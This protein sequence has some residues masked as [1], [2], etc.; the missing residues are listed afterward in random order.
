MSKKG[1][2]LILED[3]P[4]DQE[5]ITEILRRLQ[6]KNK[7]L[8]FS[9]GVAFLQY[10]QTTTDNPFIII[11]DSNIPRMNGW[12]VRQKIKEAP[13]LFEKGIPFIYFSTDGSTIA[14][15][16]AYRF[17]VQGFFIKPNTLQEME[18]VFGQIIGYWTACLYPNSG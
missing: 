14:V 7:L 10:L 17:A 5:M 2:I 15:K 6:V 18:A 3:D 11:S 13:Y 16:Q 4:D 9:D 12:Q 8:F 1:P